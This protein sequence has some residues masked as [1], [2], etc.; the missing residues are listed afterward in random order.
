M[1]RT[2]SHSDRCTLCSCGQPA[3][4][5]DAETRSPSC[6]QC[7]GS[8]TTDDE[9]PRRAIADG[10]IDDDH[11]P[12]TDRYPR[13]KHTEQ[14]VSYLSWDRDRKLR[15]LTEQYDRLEIAAAIRREIGIL[16]RLSKQRLDHRE[17][18]AIS[19]DLGIQ[20]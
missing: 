3:D 15:Y 16:S 13:L 14:P 11:D 9:Q 4:G 18:A 20:L 10:G 17:I 12:V 7:T 1:V 6:R 8:K 19:L 2:I 5:V